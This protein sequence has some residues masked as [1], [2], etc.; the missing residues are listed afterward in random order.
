[1]TEGYDGDSVTMTFDPRNLQGRPA[2]EYTIEPCSSDEFVAGL[3]AEGVYDEDFYISITGSEVVDG[4]PSD[5]PVIRVFFD[6]TNNSQEA[7]SFWSKTSIVAMQDGIQLSYNSAYDDVE[8]DANET[9]EIQ[10]GE[11]ISVSTCFSIHDTGSPVS[12]RLRDY[13]GSGDLGLP[14]R[15]SKE[16]CRGAVYFGGS[17]SAVAT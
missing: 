11:T 3:A 1:M 5:S 8:T 9:V 17:P 14:L 10:P 2:D 12:V 16:S 15:C 6:F 4:W 7:A 13:L